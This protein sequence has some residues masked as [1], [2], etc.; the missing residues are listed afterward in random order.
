MVAEAVAA[1]NEARQFYDTLHAGQVA[2]TGVTDLGYDIDGGLACGGL[3]LFLR[4]IKAVNAGLRE[5]AIVERQLTGGEYQ[6]TCLHPAHI[7]GDWFRR[8]RQGD[9]CGLQSIFRCHP[10]LSFGVSPAK[11]ACMFAKARSP[12]LVRV[13]MVALPRCGS[14][15]TFSKSR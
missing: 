14:R 1:C 7:I 11:N 8:G 12:I 3:A 10:N 4:Y 15:K 6:I 13:R 9:A 5:L 2:L